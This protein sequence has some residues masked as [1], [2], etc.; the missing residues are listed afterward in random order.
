MG[1][2]VLDRNVWVSVLSNTSFLSP[3]ILSSLMV[4]I[5][6]RQCFNIEST[7][8]PDFPYTFNAWNPVSPCRT[9]SSNRRESLT[10]G[11]GVFLQLPLL[12]ALRSKTCSTNTQQY[13]LFY[14]IDASLT[15]V[16]HHTL[17]ALSESPSPAYKMT[18]ATAVSSLP[19]ESL[20]DL[21]R[22]HG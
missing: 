21:G 17:H 11:Y 16:Y 1:S 9:L 2:I 10:S 22:R 4:V 14:V 15:A 12:V 20:R 3:T 7:L 18:F 13:Q 19:T 8:P 5:L 6:F